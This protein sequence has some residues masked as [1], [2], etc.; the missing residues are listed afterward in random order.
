MYLPDNTYLQGNR[1]KIVR[2]ISSGGFGNTYEGI[3]VMLDKRVAIKE[4]YVKDFCNRDDSTH[5]VTVGITSKTALV[6][7]LRKKFIEEAKGLSRLHH[8][9][10]INI[11]DVFEENGTAYYVMDYID[12]A[13]LGDIVKR[14]GKIAGVSA[15]KYMRQICSALEYVH[16]NNRLH[17][18]IKPGNIMVDASDNAFLIDFGASK[19]YDEEAGENTST[20]LGKTPGYAP[21]EQMG[22]DVVKFTPATDIYAVGATLYKII[23]GVTPPSATLLASGDELEPLPASVPTSVATAIHAAMRTNKTKR[24]QSIR[25]FI[26]ILDGKAG[27]DD[28]VTVL[29]VAETPT[30]KPVKEEPKPQPVPSMENDNPAPPVQQQETN[31]PERPTSKKSS[32]TVW[33]IVAA[34]AVLAIVGGA[35][36]LNKGEKDEDPVQP[37]V[38]KVVAA[39]EAAAPKVERVTNQKFKD[40]TGEEFTYTGEVKD[41]KPNGIGEGTYSFGKY[42]GPYVDGMMHGENGKFVEDGGATF[43]GKFNKDYYQEG[44]LLRTDGTYFVGTMSN[45]APSKGKWY[46]KD[47]VVTQTL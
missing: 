31:E 38:E 29:E 39:Q 43:I 14:D 47:G 6:G 4:F 42:V 24:P 2:H 18:D 36:A 20:L 33:Y 25:E 41:G 40:S 3:H 32:K 28:E 21:L 10:I 19:Q 12:G 37:I 16:A 34:V 23:T 1:Y 22:N 35:L 9:N 26:D 46:S 44:K 5:N 13:S 15:L 17:L 11:Y 45:G 7:K 8:S 30:S 27:T